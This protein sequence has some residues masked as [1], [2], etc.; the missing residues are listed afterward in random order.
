MPRNRNQQRTNTIAV[1]IVCAHATYY[2]GLFFLTARP[3]PLLSL[4]AFAGLAGPADLAR[5]CWGTGKAAAEAPSS[6]TSLGR[7]TPCSSEPPCRACRCG[8]G[9]CCCMRADCGT[10]EG[11]LRAG[12][13]E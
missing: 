9:C 12:G 5:R 4:S 6:V 11:A 10:A 3:L 1:D 7:D 8:C 2:D 13:R